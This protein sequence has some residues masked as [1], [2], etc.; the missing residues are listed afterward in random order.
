MGWRGGDVFV[1]FDS[2]KE[3]SKG[4]RGEGLG[5]EYGT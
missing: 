5:M 3:G 4:G 2:D 1:D